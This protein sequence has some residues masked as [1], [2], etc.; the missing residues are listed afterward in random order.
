MYGSPIIL[1]DIRLQLIIHVQYYSSCHARPITMHSFVIMY[2]L[3]MHVN[4]ELWT[5][6]EYVRTNR[7]NTPC[8]TACS[9]FCLCLVFG[10]IDS[11]Y[12]Y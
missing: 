9:F 10:P 4:N 2:V 6:F 8:I 7:S 12:K 11:E 1:S 5:Y 3:Q